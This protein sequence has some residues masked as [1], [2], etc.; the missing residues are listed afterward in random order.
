MTNHIV[1]DSHY[2]IAKKI[3]EYL[4]SDEIKP[5]DYRISD[6]HRKIVKEKILK[7]W[8]FNPDSIQRQLIKMPMWSVNGKRGMGS[9]WTK[10]ETPAIPIASEEPEP[11]GAGP[12]CD[13]HPQWA[14]D[15][16]HV[17]KIMGTTLLDRI[18]LLEKKINFCVG[19]LESL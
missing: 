6:I 2:Q 16:A 13:W 18:T 8:E 12:E 9:I 19:K 1:P 17:N 4:N 5:G 11:M 14:K 10:A 3:R 7:A 15:M